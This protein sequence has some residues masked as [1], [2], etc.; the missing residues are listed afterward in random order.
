VNEKLH[1]AKDPRVLKAAT[2]DQ[3]ILVTM[4]QDFAN[5][6]VFPPEETAGIAVIR[7][8]GRVTPALLAGLISSLL[9]A[10]EKKLIMG[11]LW[12]VEPGRIREHQGD[13]GSDDDD[14][15]SGS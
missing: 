13:P 15:R 5:V 12:I 1:G 2:S 14:Q 6:L 10:I 3:R 11:K 7:A 4:D 9:D 8:P